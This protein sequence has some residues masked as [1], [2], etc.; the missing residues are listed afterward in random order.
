MQNKTLSSILSIASLLIAS[1]ACSLPG[2]GPSDNGVPPANNNVPSSG[3]GSAACNN[4]L[5][6]VAVGVTWTYS[7]SGAASG[8][9]TRSITGVNS[10]GFTDQDVFDS[11]RSRTGEWKCDAGSLIALKPDSGSSNASAQSQN[12]SASFKTTSM[13]GVTLPG[14]VNPGDTWTQNFTME[15]TETI[16]GQEIPTKSAVALSCTAGATEAVSVPAGNFNAV[17]MD[18]TSSIM[19][20]I[21]MGGSEMP[22][23]VN[24]TSTMWYAPGVGMVKS[25]NIINGAQNSNLELTAYNIP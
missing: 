23:T 22:T 13:E 1:L 3:A 10:D 6:P 19:I 17:H 7:F 11:G 9:F 14:T 18:C 21:T 15:G 24:T 4:P 8:S 16:A 2:A 12:V 25:D 20:T 5:Y